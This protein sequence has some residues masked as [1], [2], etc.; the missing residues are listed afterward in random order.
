MLLED[1][2]FTVHEDGREMIVTSV[3]TWDSQRQSNNG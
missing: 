2:R 3:S 1:A